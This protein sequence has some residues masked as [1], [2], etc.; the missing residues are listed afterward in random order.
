MAKQ[1]KT[2]KRVMA[3]HKALSPEKERFCEEYVINGGNGA[4]AARKSFKNAGPRDSQTLSVKAHKLLADDRILK[5]ISELQILTKKIAEERFNL[6]AERIV[7]ELIKIAFGN[8]SDFLRIDDQGMPVVD[9]RL[10]TRDHAAAI[11]SIEIVLT[12]ASH[13]LNPT[14]DKASLRRRAVKQK[15]KLTAA[16]KLAALIALAKIL[17]L[18]DKPQPLMRKQAI[19]A[20]RVRKAIDRKRSAGQVV[21]RLE[22]TQAKAADSILLAERLRK[23]IE[24]MR[25][26]K[27][28]R[29]QPEVAETSTPQSSLAA[30]RLRPGID[31][32]RD[33][34]RVSC[35]AEL[36]AHRDR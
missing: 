19:H 12:Q 29:S 31:C 23:A 1:E 26:A 13:D 28:A 17:G 2:K 20:D 36:P 15:I 4:D 11:K 25:A 18:W 24:R 8:F 30:D 35:Q 32:I 7:E 14:C 34:G 5:R 21:P 9:L 16:D 10:M 33:P 6:T 3:P 22:G 27:Q